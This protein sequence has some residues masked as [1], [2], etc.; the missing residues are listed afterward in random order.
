MARPGH[1]A[2]D[3]NPVRPRLAALIPAYQ[4]AS[5]IQRVVQD[6]SQQVEFVLVVDDGST[7]DTAARAR[8]GGAEVVRHTVNAGKGAAL[9]TGM[10]RLQS[11]GFTHALTMDADGQHLG[12]EIPKLA[13]AVRTDPD[14]LIIGARTIGDQSVASVNLLGNRVAN[15]AVRAATGIT[16]DDTQSG[17]RVYPIAAT[18]SLPR[19]GT[20]FEYET[21]VLVRAA[22]AGIAIRSVPVDVY[23]PPVAERRTHYR[24]VLDTLRVIREM[25]PLLVRR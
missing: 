19:R 1:N 3:N 13:A 5:T 14:A 12:T 20:R 25:L 7:D 10:A 17:F 9:V 2:A 15:R 6:A 22:R 16:L 21:G 18:L 23:Y 11:L 24:K 4:A 8:T